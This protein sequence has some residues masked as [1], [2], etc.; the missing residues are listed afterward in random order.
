MNH[1]TVTGMNHNLGTNESRVS[2]VNKPANHKKLPLF[3]LSNIQSFGNSED[4]DKTTEIET[5]LDLNQVDVACLTETWL[6]ENIIYSVSINN[7]VN[8]H[9]VRKNALR[10][11]GGVSILVKDNIPACKVNIKVP[12]HIEALWVSLRPTWLPRSISNIVVGGVYYPG[13]TSEYAPNQED[14]ILHITETVHNLY[15]RYANP[16]FV[17]MGDFNDLKTNAICNACALKQV[18]KVP[19]RKEATLDLILTNKTNKFYKEPVTLPSISTSDHL[20]VLYEPVVNPKIDL[21]KNTI[22]I[23]K[24]HRSAMIAFGSWLVQFDWHVLISISD[25]NLKIEFFLNVCGS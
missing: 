10:S 4:T 19:T 13:S 23:R 12:E 9:L 24:Y 8:Y 3:L 18:V 20:C 7:Y 22:F 2:P 5:V 14:I 11:S 17:I 16:L 25:V 15:N 1:C 21:E 6:N